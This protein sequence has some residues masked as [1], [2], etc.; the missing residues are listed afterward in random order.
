MKLHFIITL[1][2]TVKVW[3][4]DVFLLFL[5]ESPYTFQ[6]EYQ[7][8]KDYPM[9]LYVLMD[10]SYSMGPSRDTLSNLGLELG[11]PVISN[12]IFS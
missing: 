6:I 4:I 1:D 8:A 12:K 7:E 11:K 5:S 9:D 2:K 3:S 10:L